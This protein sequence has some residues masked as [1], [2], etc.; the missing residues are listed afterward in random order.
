MD[1]TLSKNVVIFKASQRKN[2]TQMLHIESM[3]LTVMKSVILKPFFK[4]KN[5]NLQLKALA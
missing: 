4:F 3:I 5:T 1:D 2:R